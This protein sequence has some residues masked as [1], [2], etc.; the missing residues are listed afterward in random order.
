MVFVRRASRLRVLACLAAWPLGAAGCYNPADAQLRRENVRLAGRA[1]DL[2]QRLAASQEA[3]ERLEREL[4]EARGLSELDR[5]ALILP[6]RVE[7]VRLTGGEDYDGE[8]GDDGVTV[9]LRPLDE[10]GDALKVAGDVRIELFDLAAGGQRIGLC[11]VSAAELP[12]RWLGALMTDH[13]TIRCPFD[14][15][16]SSPEVTVR[17]T[18]VDYL[19]KRSLTAQQV[20]EVR[21][22][23]SEGRSAP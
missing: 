16:P 3:I 2:E 6:A 17:V 14:R 1:A 11:E 18:F 10:Q 4:D 7:L 13:Y 15:A 8:P 20:V 9:H 5:S 19:S 23:G 12:E 22:S 21:V